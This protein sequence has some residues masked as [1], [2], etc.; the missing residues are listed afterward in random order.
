MQEKELS[1]FELMKKYSKEDQS[2][3]EKLLKMHK[4]RKVYQHGLKP[5]QVE[6]S[7]NK[8]VSML[9]ESAKYLLDSGKGKRP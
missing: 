5:R 1:G 6:S 3:K 2:S 4:L 9:Q 7:I 8:V